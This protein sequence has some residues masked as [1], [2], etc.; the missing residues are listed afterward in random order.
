MQLNSGFR[1]S[2]F[3][4][5]AVFAVFVTH[6]YSAFAQS[7][8]TLRSIIPNSSVELIMKWIPPGTFTMGS[9]LGEPGRNNNEDYQYNIT[10]TRGFYM[11]I[12][13]VTQEQYQAVMDWNANGANSTPSHF[14]NNPAA[15]EVQARR[16]VEDV[17]WYEAILFCNR[18]SILEGLTPVYSIEGSTNPAIWGTVPSRDSFFWNDVTVNWNANG[19]RL[20][21]EA[22]WEYACRAGTT[23]AWYTGNTENAA[24]QAAAWY[25]ANNDNGTRQVGLKTPNAWGLYDMHGNVWEWVW[26]WYD[27]STSGSWSDDPRGPASGTR[28]VARGGSWGAS[29]ASLR[30]ASRAEGSAWLRLNFFGFRV[31]RNQ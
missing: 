28:R 21:T 27:S 10:L 30:S 9:S 15:G 29:A 4:L 18:L 2:A 3:L 14:G 24:L 8:T 17:S 25:R 26:D 6:T 1:F 7:A 12:Y 20:P 16:P 19:Y 22:E 11:G 5:L 13:P 23:T 31:V